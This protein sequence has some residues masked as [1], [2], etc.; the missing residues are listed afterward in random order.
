M[1][2]V[3]PEISKRGRY[4]I[5]KHRYYELKHH[6]LQ[7][8]DWKRQLNEIEYGP[9]SVIFTD[10]PKAE[11]V[12]DE[13]G[14]TAVELARLKLLIANVEQAAHDADAGLDRYILAAVTQGRSYVYLHER[15]GMPCGRD[16]FYARYR[17]FFWLLDKL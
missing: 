8:P 17:K 13:T 2:T 15:M 1:A 9:R 4:W 14:N 6:C 5:P 16:Y 12:N 10:M 3:R 11:G 7:Y